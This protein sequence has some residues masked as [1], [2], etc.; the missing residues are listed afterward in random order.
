MDDALSANF[1]KRAP[2]QD[3]IRVKIQLNRIASKK[4]VLKRDWM[5]DDSIL[6]HAHH[7]SGC[8]NQFPC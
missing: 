3:E 8:R 2:E 5:K 6:K 7:A 4:Q 1:W